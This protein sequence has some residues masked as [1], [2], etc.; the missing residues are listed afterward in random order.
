MAGMQLLGDR[1]QSEACRPGRAAT[2]LWVCSV[3][4]DNSGLEGITFY[5]YMR[6][7]KS[8]VIYDA[9]SY[10]RG[11]RMP[12]PR[13]DKHMRRITVAV[14]YDD[15]EKVGC[16]ARS[17]DASVLRVIRRAIRE[18]LDCYGVDIRGPGTA[19]NRCKVD[20]HV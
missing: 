3:S 1:R 17:R 14:G 6:F 11:M 4:G 2:A 13:K 12:F 15:Y 10:I 9:K 19:S 7:I 8:M 16:L 18:F 5:P 20:W